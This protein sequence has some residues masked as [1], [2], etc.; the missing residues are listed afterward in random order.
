MKMIWEGKN[1]DVFWSVNT[2]GLYYV[3][4]M[5]KISQEQFEELKFTDALKDCSLQDATAIMQASKKFKKCYFGFTI[6]EEDLPKVKPG[7]K[8]KKKS[9]P[10]EVEPLTTSLGD[11]LKGI[12]LT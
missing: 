8:I 6:M 4:D 1:V 7:N 10:R 11:L 3:M 9:S 5:S 12:S 2:P